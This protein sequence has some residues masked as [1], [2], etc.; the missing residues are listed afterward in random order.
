VLIWIL[1]MYIFVMYRY[2]RDFKEAKERLKGLIE[3]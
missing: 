1:G 3:Q 2:N